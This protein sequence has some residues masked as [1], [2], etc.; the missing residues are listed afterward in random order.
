[1]GPVGFG[2]GTILDVGGGGS[3]RGLDCE[4]LL[5]EAVTMVGKEWK[6]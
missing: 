1:M 4:F 2:N 5:Y 3:S 6:Q